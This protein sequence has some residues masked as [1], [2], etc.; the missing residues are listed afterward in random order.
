MIRLPLRY[1]GTPVD[2][3]RVERPEGGWIE[4]DAAWL[5]PDNTLVPIDELW[6]DH[7]ALLLER[8]SSRIWRLVTPGG[9]FRVVFSAFV[10]EHPT[11]VARLL[12][13]GRTR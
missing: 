9:S 4:I 3:G 1:D 6:L 12:I 2:L 7:P 8:K 10:D 13:A 11:L 5:A